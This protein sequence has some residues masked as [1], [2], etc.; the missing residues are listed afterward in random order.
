M[1]DLEAKKVQESWRFVLANSTDIGKMFYERLFELV[2]EL[3]VYFKTD[4]ALQSEKFTSTITVILAKA[5]GGYSFMGDVKH[6][7]S[8]HSMYGARAEHYDRVGE[9][10]LWTLEKAMGNKWDN[11]LK[12]IW[13]SMYCQLS[14]LMIKSSEGHEENSDVA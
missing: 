11:E 9:A 8:R 13:K 4:I 12:S 1:T 7:A 3:K 5:Y 14:E 6:L 10:L 2:P